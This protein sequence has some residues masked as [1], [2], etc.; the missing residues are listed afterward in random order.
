MVRYPGSNVSLE[1]L[2]SRVSKFIPSWRSRLSKY[3]VETYGFLKGNE[4]IVQILLFGWL[5]EIKSFYDNI[6]PVYLK[7]LYYSNSLKY[8]DY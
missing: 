8:N 7:M 6:S 3:K 4:D 2:F 1:R 5:P